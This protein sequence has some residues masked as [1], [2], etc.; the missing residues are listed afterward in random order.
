MRKRGLLLLVFVLASPAPVKAASTMPIY[1]CVQSKAIHYD[2][3]E[4]PVVETTVFKYR[5]DGQLKSAKAK[6]SYKTLSYKNNKLVGIRQRLGDTYY[7]KVT[8]NKASQIVKANIVK[9]KETQRITLGYNKQGLL[10]KEKNVYQSRSSQI[11]STDSVNYVYDDNMHMSAIIGHQSFALNGENGENEYYDLLNTKVNKNKCTT[12]VLH[13]NDDEKISL[14][15]YSYK[16]IKVKPSLVKAI[17]SQQGYM[18]YRYDLNWG[19]Q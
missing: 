17:R 2:E 19:F 12:Q 9:N 15:T 3:T 6:Y 8:L 10:Q 18:I 4:E 11:G 16:K 13:Y 7:A 5:K 1:I 14:T